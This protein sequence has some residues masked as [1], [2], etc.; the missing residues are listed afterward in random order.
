[1]PTPFWSPRAEDLLAELGAS[2]GGLSAAEA[3]RRLR[4][5]GPN[6]I[7]D[8]HAA[9]ALGLLLNQFRSPLVLL[10]LFAM[11]LS[12]LGETTAG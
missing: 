10:L 8:A 6:R 9:T 2:A 3:A 11:T 7:S 5:V 4:Q 12:L 1:V